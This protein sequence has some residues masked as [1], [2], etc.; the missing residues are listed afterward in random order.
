MG[1]GSIQIDI[2]MFEIRDRLNP[3]LQT[4]FHESAPVL[5]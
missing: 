3:V 1:H 4:W 5:P 2:T